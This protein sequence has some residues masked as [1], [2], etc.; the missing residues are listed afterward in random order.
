MSDVD[1]NIQLN[2]GSGGATIA[3]DYISNTHYQIIKIAHGDENVAYRTTRTQPIPVSIEQIELSNHTNPFLAVAGSTDGTDPVVVSIS[4]NS[5]LNVD[6]VGINGGS[7]LDWVG[8]V[9]EGVSCDIRGFDENASLSN[10][11]SVGSVGSIGSNVSVELKSID[12]STTLPTVSSVGSIE[13]NVS[14][15]LKSIDS[16]TVM[17]VKSAGTDTVSVADGVVLGQASADTYIGDVSV[18]TGPDLP[19]SFVVGEIH[20]LKDGPLSPLLG[21][22]ALKSGIRIKNIGDANGSTVVIASTTNNDG[23]PP[24]DGGYHLAPGE[25]VFL[26]IINTNKIY[27]WANDW[28]TDGIDGKICWIGS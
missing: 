17:N 12:S 20:N 2:P 19:D 9:A 27:V 7:T 24:D 6:S 4:G 28:S 13:S 1:P 3:S 14:V 26:E 5:T 11:T 23:G 21:A 15:D 18:S 25:N 16:S 8:S 22:H 10:V